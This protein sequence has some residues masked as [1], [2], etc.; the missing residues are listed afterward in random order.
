MAFIIASKRIKYVG[1]N[2]TE[3]VEDLYTK[4]KKKLLEEIKEDTN[5]R[6]DILCS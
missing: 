3:E 1:I 5:K 4:N 6:E 2:L